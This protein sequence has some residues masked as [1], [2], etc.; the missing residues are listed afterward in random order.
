MTDLEILADEFSK[1]WQTLKMRHIDL[2]AHQTVIAGLL[3]KQPDLTQA[4]NDALNDPK[5][6]HVVLE[7][8]NPQYAS[9]LEGLLRKF[10]DALPPTVLKQLSSLENL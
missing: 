8:L 1:V 3:K 9:I 5:Q 6:R 4:V 2:A 10:S 7:E